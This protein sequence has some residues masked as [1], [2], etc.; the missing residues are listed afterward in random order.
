MRAWI[1][2]AR[3]WLR[4][5]VSPTRMLRDLE[6][7]PYRGAPLYFHPQRGLYVRS[8]RSVAEW[9]RNMRRALA[10]ARPS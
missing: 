2:V 7:L 6:V 3:T 4:A 1:V 5:V 10:R 8:A 9:R